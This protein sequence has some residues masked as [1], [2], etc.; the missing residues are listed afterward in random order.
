MPLATSSRPISSTHKEAVHLKA[1]TNM[2]RVLPIPM[3]LSADIGTWENA[4]WNHAGTNIYVASARCITKRKTA[5]VP[6]QAAVTDP[7]WLCPTWTR[8]FIWSSSSPLLTP[9]ASSTETTLPFLYVPASELQNSSALQNISSHPDLFKIVTTV[10][11]ERLNKLLVTHPN[12][13]LVDSVCLGLREGVWPFVNINPAA[14]ETFEG[15]QHALNAEA[16]QFM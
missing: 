1:R 12:R 5:P 2:P 6:L 9:S 16:T 13:A 3:H 14:P 4:Q 8:G 10:K 15:S 7:R 11:A